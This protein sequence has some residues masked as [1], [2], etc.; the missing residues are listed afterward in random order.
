METIYRQ[1]AFHRLTDIQKQAKLQKDSEYE[2]A[3]QNLTVSWKKGEIT[4]EAYRQQK[5]TLWH[6]YKN[7]AISQ[8]LYEQITP[9]QQ[10]TEAEATLREQVN[11]VNLIRKE[12]GKPEV[13]IKEKAGPK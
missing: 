10:L 2:I 1:K 11:Q 8:G 3:V 9:E 12:L 13:E 4:Q 5:S 6:T 7:W